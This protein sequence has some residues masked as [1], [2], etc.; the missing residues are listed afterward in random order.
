[1]A[2][3]CV[4]TDTLNITDSS[5]SGRAGL[6]SEEGKFTEISALLEAVDLHF[7]L[8]RIIVL[9]AIIILLLHLLGDH[10]VSLHNNVK[11]VA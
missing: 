5:H 4:Q 10:D 11:A 2:T 6:V 1:M 3:F 9:C 7:H 8:A